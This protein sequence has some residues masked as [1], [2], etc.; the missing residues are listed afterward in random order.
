MSERMFF[1][2]YLASQRLA[3]KIGEIAGPANE[4]YTVLMTAM[5]LAD[6][7]NLDVLSEYWPGLYR[8]LMARYNA[9]GGALTPEELACL[10]T[11]GQ[12][13]DSDEGEG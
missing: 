12:N 1:Y 13:T 11:W 10:K 2:E 5:R 6:T 9:P 3:S 8:E 7:D 4:F